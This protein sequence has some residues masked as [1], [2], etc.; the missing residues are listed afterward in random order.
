MLSFWQ[1]ESGERL[2]RCRYFG[3]GGVRAVLGRGNLKVFAVRT[4]TALIPTQRVICK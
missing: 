4:M 2:D 1:L 3:G